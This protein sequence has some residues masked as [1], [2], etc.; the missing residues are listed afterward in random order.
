MFNKTK[1]ILAFLLAAIMVFSLVGCSSSDD[2][3]SVIYEE[4]IVYVDGQGNPTSSGSSDG[5]GNDG[6]STDNPSSDTPGAV[7]INDNVDPEKY[8]GTTVKFAATIHP[9]NDESGPVVDQFEKDYGIKVEVS[10]VDQNNFAQEIQ[11]KIAA[12]NSPDVVRVN[13]DFPTC[14]GYL[15]S[16]DA[17]KLDYNEAIWKQETFNISTFGGS[18]YIC[19]TVNN[20]WGEIDLVIYSKSLLKRAGANTP[21]EYDAAGKWTWDAY[22]DIC[23]KIKALGSHMQ[24]GGF[25]S[26]EMAIHAMGGGLIALEDGVFVSGVNQRTQEA[27]VKYTEAWKEGIIGWKTTDGFVDGTVG[28]SVCHIWALKT[29][30][31][32]GSTT[33]NTS[34]LG[35][36]YI[37]R[38]DENSDYGNTG[39]VRGWGICRGAPNPVA[40]GI[41]LREYLDVSNYD[42]SSTFISAEAEEFFF[43]L[44]SIDY[45]NWNP[46][47][48]YMHYQNAIAGSDI[49][50][51]DF[52]MAMSEDPAQIGSVMA[53][54][55]GTMEKAADNINKFVKQNTGIK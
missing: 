18:P 24:G 33:Y 1:R 19:D 40:A 47:I 32:F 6:T 21:E 45:S 16:L 53:S 8:R 41:F 52:Y 2:D 28:I 38:W 55:K 46:Q 17:A 37:P 14:M 39:M 54:V 31:F 27:M 12:G 26:R 42:T 5:S 50:T 44:T 3:G 22:F 9:D 29:T 13:G 15:Q 35:F 25:G 11:A 30:G 7:T 43:K 49:S 36:Y 34:D 10:I 51:S 48:L 23:R 4:E 20:I